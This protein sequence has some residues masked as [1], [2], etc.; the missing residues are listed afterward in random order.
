MSL[1]GKH[2]ILGGILV[3]S[4]G[5]FLLYDKL[6]NTDSLSSIV[7]AYGVTSIAMG[8]HLMEQ[9]NAISG[10]WKYISIIIITSVGFAIGQYALLPVLSVVSIAGLII[11]VATYVLHD[12]QQYAPEIPSSVVKDGS[13]IIGLIIAVSQVIQQQNPQTV[14]EIVS[15][16]IVTG[17]TYYYQN[18]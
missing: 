18:L 6:L 14:Q 2:F 7:A 15:I 3:L 16:I 8:I 13:L 11:V 5:L 4:V 9:S 1:S 10:Y 12:I 17:L